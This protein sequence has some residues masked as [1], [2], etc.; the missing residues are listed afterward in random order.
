MFFGWCQKQTC[1]FIFPVILRC[2]DECLWHICSCFSQ[3]DWSQ[4]PRRFLPLP[5]RRN[6]R[7]GRG[8]QQKRMKAARMIQSSLLP[9]LFCLKDMCLTCRR[10]WFSPENARE[11]SG[12]TWKNKLKLIWVKH[13]SCLN[14]LGLFF[15]HKQSLE[16]P[17]DYLLL[18][19]P[20][21][22]GF[23]PIESASLVTFVMWIPTACRRTSPT[24][25]ACSCV[26][27][28]HERSASKFLLI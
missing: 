12:H 22:S 15:P 24:A 21:Q 3:M 17:A 13:V 14:A 26:H 7:Q 23:V 1:L 6:L 20:L 4:I 18:P 25:W 5:L 2:D 10:K 8:K 11:A 27:S 28:D 16:A 9:S 19:K